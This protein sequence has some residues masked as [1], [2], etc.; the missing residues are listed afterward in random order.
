MPELPVRPDIVVLLTDVGPS[1]LDPDHLHRRDGSPFTAA[2]HDLILTCTPAEITAAK[3]QKRLENDWAREHQAMQKALVDLFTKYVDQ[4]P[5]GTL[6]SA[7]EVYGLMTDEDY[8]ECAR[9]VEALKARDPFKYR[10]EP[11]QD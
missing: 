1:R 8:T 11:G 7:G 3:A 10:T 4:L 6:C 5:D 2:E 9:L